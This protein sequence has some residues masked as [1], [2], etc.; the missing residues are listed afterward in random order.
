MRNPFKFFVELA[1]QPLWIPLWVSLL[2]LVN[3]ASAAFW[4]EPTAKLI[5]ITFMIS[6]MLM[7]GLYSWFG[8]A[9]IL[10]FGH[11][12]W[13]PLLLHVLTRL[14]HAGGALQV[15]LVAWSV[16]TLVSLA[17]DAVDVWKFF[18]AKK[19]TTSRE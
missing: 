1:R 15:Y 19:P 5:L 2:M 7:M 6:S 3:F 17:F 16:V 8:F 13:I 14:P 9:K 4:S 18:T 11:V 12:L 10:G